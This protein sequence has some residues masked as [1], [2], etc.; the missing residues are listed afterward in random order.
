MTLNDL[1]HR[2]QVA[3]MRADSARSSEAQVAHRGLAAGYAALIVDMQR[4]MGIVNPRPVLA[5]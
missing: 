3:V 5:K 4:G 1:F 2:H